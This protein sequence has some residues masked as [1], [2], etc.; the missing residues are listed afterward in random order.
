MHDPRVQDMPNGPFRPEFV[1]LYKEVRSRHHLTVRDIALAAGI[2]E[3]Y[4]GNATRY[5]HNKVKVSVTKANPVG[6]VVFAL[7]GATTEEEARL[8]LNGGALVPAAHSPPRESKTDER[9]EPESLERALAI[10]RR[11]G[12]RC[13]QLAH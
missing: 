3:S 7:H 6:I 2:S 12:V 4:L 5:D 11:H 13:L 10:M 9:S 8:A 1:A